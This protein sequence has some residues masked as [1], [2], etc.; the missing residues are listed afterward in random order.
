MK[1]TRQLLAII[2]AAVLLALAGDCSCQEPAHLV[3]VRLADGS[4]VRVTVQQESLDVQTRYGK[5]T[6]PINEIKRIEF[7]LHYP[8]EL[9]SALLAQRVKLGSSV[10]AEREE[11]SAALL[12]GGHFSCPML[13]EA[14]KSKD[15]EIVRRAE[16]LLKDI[17]VGVAPGLLAI[18][19]HDTLFTIGGT[20]NGRIRAAALKTDSA[21]F[22]KIA[23]KL[24]D[25][26][27]LQSRADA[28][29]T[30]VMVDAALF[31]DAWLDTGVTVDGSLTLTAAASGQVDLW[32]QTPGQYIATPKG[33]NAVGKVTPF[34]AG[35]LI[36]RIGETGRAFLIG[37]R[38]E[39]PAAEEGKLYL[40]I[41]PS[42]WNSPSA[43]SFN[44]RINTSPR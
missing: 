21:T 2:A 37:E 36:G 41:V 12:K 15:Q 10:H 16:K 32:P 17:G 29:G 14:L 44:V 7:G 22:G 26:R 4:K 43:G 35:A 28:A 23:I 38:Y 33:Y 24:T 42:P 1:A 6:V 19:E 11:A 34:M 3:E 40:Q 13:R 39:A 20:I 18:K 27:F 31:S 25:L 30:Q 8:G 9:E 5:L